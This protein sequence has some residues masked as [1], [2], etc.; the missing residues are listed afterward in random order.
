LL[1]FFGSVC[2]SSEGN[3]ILAENASNILL[4]AFF[5][6]AEISGALASR[7]REGKDLIR[8]ETGHE[9]ARIF[10]NESMNRKPTQIVATLVGVIRANS[11]LAFLGD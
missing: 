2:L 5:L 7:K 1:K 6:N 4:D 3:G 11:W 9:S 8:E 10:T